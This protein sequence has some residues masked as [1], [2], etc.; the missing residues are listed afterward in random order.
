M[1]LLHLIVD[2]STKEY[3]IL[4]ITDQYVNIFNSNTNT[5][6]TSVMDPR[7]TSPGLVSSACA[8]GR[9]YV[10]S[11]ATW[12][13]PTTPNHTRLNL[14]LEV[15]DIEPDEWQHYDLT[16]DL[17]EAK[18][19]D[20][21]SDDL[22]EL[23]SYPWIGSCRGD[24]YV[25]ASTWH[26]KCSSLVKFSHTRMELRFHIYK[27]RRKGDRILEAL[28]HVVTVPADCE[29]KIKKDHKYCRDYLCKYSCTVRGNFICLAVGYI[30]LLQYDVLSGVITRYKYTDHLYSGR[31]SQ[32]LAVLKNIT[33]L[34]MTYTPRSDFNLLRN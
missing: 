21:H 22:K 23:I 31:I 29:F 19:C 8:N 12:N 11:S 10:C 17:P 15:L 9:V 20:F 24:V 5:W 28:E 18:I 6:R 26:C 32:K 3:K 2:D 4:R 30:Q 1:F 7:Y 13:N 34:N 16:L 14:K 33:G 27:L 25:V